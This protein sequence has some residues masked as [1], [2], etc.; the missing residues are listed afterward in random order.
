MHGL[1]SL[2]TVL[3]NIKERLSGQS[4]HRDIRSSKYYD[5]SQKEMNGK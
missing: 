4:V 1:F 5:R 2:E 3:K